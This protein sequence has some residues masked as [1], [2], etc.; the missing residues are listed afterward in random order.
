MN[1]MVKTRPAII[2]VITGTKENEIA[3]IP[4]ED[5][6]ILQSKDVYVVVIRGKISEYD[7]S[8]IDEQ[9]RGRPQGATYDADVPGYYSPSQQKIVIVVF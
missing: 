4:A 6:R 5:A 1:T 7:P 2:S 9:P 8:K 3:K